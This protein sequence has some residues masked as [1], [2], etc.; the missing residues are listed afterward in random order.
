MPPAGAERE[1]K[2]L[3]RETCAITGTAAEGCSM[4]RIDPRH[5]EGT[6]E[7]AALSSDSTRSRIAST[8]TAPRP[9]KAE[10]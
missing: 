1:T 2:R 6:E 9:A 8:Y 7:R 3:T 10:D 4:A 5:N